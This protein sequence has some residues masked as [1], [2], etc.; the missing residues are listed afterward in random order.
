MSDSIKSFYDSIQ[1]I[2]DIQQLIDDEERESVTLDYKQADR[3]WNHTA[4]TKI[5]RHISAF[6]NSE[7]GILVFGVECDEQDKDRP[8][9]IKG[10]HPQNAV[11]DLDRIV[12]AA[13]RPEIKGWERKKISDDHRDV[14]L[15]YI[16]ASDAGPHQSMKHKQYFHRS[17]A[18]SIA[19]EHYLVQRYFGR[20]FSPLLNIE[21][22]APGGLR[23][24][25]PKKDW[26][27]YYPIQFVIRNNGKGNANG[28]SG[29]LVLPTSQY[30]STSHAATYFNTQVEQTRSWE[31]KVSGPHYFIISR[32][33]HPGASYCFFELAVAF[34]RHHIDR[35]AKMPFLDW[36]IF[37]EGM[38]PQKG[39]YSLPKEFIAMLKNS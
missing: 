26:T 35:F 36:E 7:G 29:H 21:V 12:T 22:T 38:I 16:P 4:K 31:E 3:R 17:G 2:A 8:V 25:Y 9:S 11:E 20:H 24:M 30:V 10:L 15:V 6:A 19:M 34:H 33:I 27:H 1:S 37:A 18:Q 28:C 13:I 39:Q 23:A 5:A 14:L 32:D